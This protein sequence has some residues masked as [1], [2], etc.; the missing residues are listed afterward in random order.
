MAR[1]IRSCSIALAAVCAA[2]S[3][4]SAQ[5]RAASAD[6]RADSMRLG[7]SFGVV[8]GIVSDTNLAPL[9]GAFVTVLSTKIRV[10]TGPNGRFRITRVPPGEYLIF[11]KRVG[12]RPTSAVIEVA[13]GDT[14]RLS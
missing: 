5:A 10:G 3:V 1:F 14:A 13:A 11:V 8:D 7:R 9:Q 2:A 12:Y 6:A 4:S